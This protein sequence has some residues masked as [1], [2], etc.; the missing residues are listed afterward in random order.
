M[1]PVSELLTYV[2]T[3]LGCGYVWGTKGE[4]CT[5]SLLETLRIR[6]KDSASTPWHDGN[7]GYTYKGRCVRWIGKQVFDCGGLFDYLFGIN[8]TAQGYYS[9][10]TIKGK[11]D[12]M[13][14]VPGIQLFEYSSDSGTMYHVGCYMGNNK[15]IEARGADYGVVETTVAGRGW[16][17]WA[18]CYLIDYSE[19][20]MDI[21]CKYGDGRETSTSFSKEVWAMQDCLIKLGFKMISDKEYPADGR[22]GNATVNGVQSFKTR[23]GLPGD[24]KAFEKDCVTFLLEELYD[25]ETGVP[26]ATYDA[27]VAKVAS[28]TADIL[29]EKAKV[30]AL[31]TQVTSMD[32]EIVR[33]GNDYIAVNTEKNR[34]SGLLAELKAMKIRKDAILS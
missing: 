11:M 10:A 6:Y 33:L 22:Y 4:M 28:L 13:P 19:A 12:T 5:E 34:L 27:E 20:Y 24:G 32:Q 25:L 3:K 21:Y 29:T 8:T 26:Q 15:A 30:T 23:F 9:N 18:Y 2:P 31:E 17:H 16:D 14:D 1:K 7:N